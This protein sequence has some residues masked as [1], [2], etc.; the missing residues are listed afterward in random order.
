MLK[1][2]KPLFELGFAL[3]CLR[4]KSKAPVESKWSSREKDSWGELK[5]KYKSGQNLG[6][7]LGRASKLKDGTYLG[8]IDCD[9]KSGKAADTR[10]MLKALSELVEVSAGAICMSGRGNGSQHVYVRTKKPATPRR[11]TQSKNKVKV[12]MPSVVKVSRYER[13][14]LSAKEI[15]KG[16]RIRPAWEISIMGEGQQV[17]IPPSIHPDS[18]RV[19]RWSPMP[20][21]IGDIPLFK[22]SDLETRKDGPSS[23][24]DISQDVTFQVVDLTRSR[25]PADTVD[26]ILSGEGVEDRSHALYKVASRM[27]NTGF[28]NDEI[29]SVLTEREYFLGSVAYEHA[30]TESRKRAARWLLKY[31]VS[32]VRASI[33]AKAA[34]E[35][36]VIDEPAEPGKSKASNGAITER[37]WRDELKRHGNDQLKTGFVNIK[38]ILQGYMSDKIDGPFIIHDSFA[39]RS[40]WL[41]D[42]PWRSLKGQPG[43]DLDLVRIKSWMSRHFSGIEV[44]KND[45]YDVLIDLA[46]ENS[47][48]PVRDYLNSLKWD[49]KERLNYWLIDCLKAKGPYQYLAAV[50]RKTLVAAVARI[51]EPGKK[52]DQ[53]L[54]L[55]GEQDVGKSTT[56]RILAGDPWFADTKLDFNNKDAVVGMQGVW[57][58]ELGEL[59]SLSKRDLDTT[60]EFISRQT[61]KIRVPYGK[62]MQEF[63]RQGIFIGTTNNDDYLRDPTGNRRFWPVTVRK[64]NFKRLRA[65]RDQLWAEAVVRYKEGEKLYIDSTEHP[66]L[67]RIEKAEQAK[68][69]PQDSHEDAIK[70]FLTT[71]HPP[72]FDP[73]CFRMYDLLES[74]ITFGVRGLKVDKSTETKVGYILKKIG[75]S[76][77][78]DIRIDGKKGNFWRRISEPPK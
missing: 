4:P 9:V 29:A 42:C 43:T 44:N 66:E 22:T 19:Y 70:D 56:G 49:G 61:D 33:S 5:A 71:N 59:S 34:F 73:N 26:M 65:W 20:I 7:R 48:H 32:K 31:T 58:Y 74:A 3:H 53:V 62:L 17:V 15:K 72:G 38:K 12:L 63:P 10:D 51:F 30:Q 57:I 35:Q 68:R 39:V 64:V 25:L 55:E 78:R 28:T 45:I 46:D 16:I 76:C 14:H 52:F 23:A 37:T 60:K 50:G 2:V 54:V 18:G 75:F 1:D 67:K 36:T 40:S 69:M 24:D 11:L 77:H 47:H 13:D 21:D 8:V 27:V 6:V 41:V